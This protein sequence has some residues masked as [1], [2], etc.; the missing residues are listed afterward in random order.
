MALLFKRGRLGEGGGRRDEDAA[1]VGDRP[2]E[3]G[4][5]VI[6]AK[7]GRQVSVSFEVV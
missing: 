2:G 4:G 1:V 5:S 6:F 3:R 7:Q